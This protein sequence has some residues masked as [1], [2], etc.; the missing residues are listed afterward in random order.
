MSD[1]SI[2]DIK[3]RIFG[4]ILFAEDIGGALR[5]WRQFFR[6]SQVELA[7]F[8]KISSSVLSEYENDPEK[9]PGARFIK[10]YVDSL[11]E[12]DMLR[13]GKVLSLLTTGDI[14]LEFTREI[15]RMRDFVNPLTAKNYV[16]ILDVEVL[17]GPENLDDIKLYGYTMLDSLAAIM[18]MSGPVYYKIFGRTTERALLFTNVMSGRSPMVAVRVYP[19][20]P[21]MV[22]LHGPKKVDDLAI[23]IADKEHMVL[24]VCR[25]KADRD[26]IRSLEILDKFHRE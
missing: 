13:G 19:L 22:I 23:K 7:R 8:M 10:R 14:S 26:I 16:D 17:V 21:R 12:I 15:I 4:D 9:S 25:L 11:I 5:K 1:E 18:S 3:K 2:A 20:K 24:G 6:V